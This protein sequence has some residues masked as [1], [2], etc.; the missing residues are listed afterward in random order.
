VVTLSTG[1]PAGI[2]AIAFAVREI[3]Q[4]NIDIAIVGGTDAPISP[5]TVAAFWASGGL[6]S[7]YNDVPE[8]ASRPFDNRRS[9]YVLSEG[10]GMVILE[11][12]GHASSRSANLYGEVSGYALTN[13]A[14]NLY[15]IDP[16]GDGLLWSMRR[17]LADAR[18]IPQEIEYISA[19]GPSIVLTDR[20]ETTAIKRLF[21]EYAFR[22]PI[23]SIKSMIGQPL[24]ATPMLQ[25]AS[26][27]L[28]FRDH[29][30]PPTINYEVPDPAC[31]LDYVPNR[32]RTKTVETALINAHGYG[33][34]NASLVVRKIS[35]ETRILN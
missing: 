24:G 14:V 25:L 29:I 32:A 16:S 13:D 15:D 26:C 2:T 8:K 23:S 11:E 10:A 1:C 3:E 20:A 9:G 4:G 18:L 27:L 33:G 19:H 7:D 28:T 5:T 6:T 22:V 21:G 12:L 35:Q 30:L 31:D 17:A 34:I